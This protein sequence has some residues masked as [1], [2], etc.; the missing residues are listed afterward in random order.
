VSGLLLYVPSDQ[1]VERQEAH[2]WEFIRIVQ[3]IAGR[4]ASGRMV[5]VCPA[6]SSSSA[7][8]TGASKAVPLELPE[9]SV[10]RVHVPPSLDVLSGCGALGTIGAIEAVAVGW[11]GWIASLAREHA[12]ESDLWLDPRAPHPL[13][14]P[15][16]SP[17][18]VSLPPSSAPAVDPEGVYLVTGG[19]GGVGGAL[20][21]WLLYEQGVPPPNVVLLSRRA[22]SPP[23]EGVRVAQ[24]DISSRE[25]LASCAALASLPD[26]SGIFHLA[27]VLD[28]GLLT[29][30]TPNRLHTAVKPKAGVLHL[31][32]VCAARRWSPSW[33]VAASSTSSLFG[34][35]GQSNYCAANGLLDHLATFGL[36]AAATGGGEARAP[37]VLTLNF[38]PWGEVGMAREGTK[39]HQLSLQSG[40]LPMASSAAIACVAEALR[41][42]RARIG[43]EELGGERPNAADDAAGAPLGGGGMQFA[44]ADV[45]WWR[46]PWPSHPLLQGVMHRLPPPPPPP[47]PQEEAGGTGARGHEDEDEGEDEEVG[48]ATSRRLRRARERRRQSDRARAAKQKQSRGLGAREV[49]GGSVASVPKGGG[50]DG[51]GAERVASFLRSR[52][53]V[54]QTDLPLS[55]LGLDSLDLVQLRNN[56]QKAFKRNVPMATFTN[57][58]QTLDELMAKLVEKV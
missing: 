16:L 14:A 22:I 21:A 1:P 38:G 34:Y 6:S 53:S 26:V 11:L 55:D 39:A 44:V 57:A 30:M 7:L 18:P 29:N 40:E 58:Q 47:P 54:W 50:A 42:L 3:G 15:R 8:V 13:R 9:L 10:Q 52:L 28:D 20:V 56:F 46:S 23:H 5:L 37:R 48:S 31:L 51:G 27:G 35:A 2:C 12:R 25:S 17:R 43:S 36:P 49:A 41:Q 19:T 45:E 32:E 33:L 4:G 24:A